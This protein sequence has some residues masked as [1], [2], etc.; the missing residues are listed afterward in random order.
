MVFLGRIG[1]PIRNIHLD[2]GTDLVHDQ[3]FH[4]SVIV[5]YEV[6]YLCMNVCD[7]F[8]RRRPSDN[9]WQ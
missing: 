6:K 1:F 4:F 7:T 9:E 8:W 5:K 3:Y 2:F